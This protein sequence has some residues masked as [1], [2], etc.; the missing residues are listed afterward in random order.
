MLLALALSILL[1]VL[2]I[3]IFVFACC[4]QHAPSSNRRGG[5]QRRV[6]ENFRRIPFAKDIFKHSSDCSICLMP[7]EEKDDIIV[8]PCNEKHYF[9]ST[10]ITDWL[11]QENCCPMCRK[12]VE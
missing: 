9:H 3:V 11:L 5:I 2:L 12:P 8:L 10:C 4:P 6:V 7:F 1:L